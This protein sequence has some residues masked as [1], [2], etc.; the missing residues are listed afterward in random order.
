MK[1]TTYLLF[2]FLFLASITYAQEA[3]N[4]TQTV[5]GTVVDK[6]LET[7]LPGAT[8]ILLNTN[9]PVGAVTDAD[10]KFEMKV[11]FGRQSF[12]ASFIG[13]EAQTIPEVLV[14]AGKQVSLDIKL[15]ESVNKIK[16][17]T[18]SANSEKDRASNEYSTVSARTFSM[19]EVTRY[20]GGRND[21]ARLV[22][23]FA[24]VNTSNDARNDIV[25][26]GN[27]PAGILWRLEGIPIPNPNHF[28]TLGT[29][30]GPVSALN[31]NLL[32][33][34]DFLT[35]AF[36]AEYGNA[37]GGVFDVGF[38]SGNS[39]KHEF[40]FQLNMFSG[41]EAMAEGPMKKNKDASYLISYR[42]SFAGIGAAM[43][44]P[45]GTAAAPQYQDLS[46]KFD[47]ANSKKFGKL[48]VFGIGAYS[49]INF[50]G[51]KLTTED[52]F[53]DPYSDRYV[54][55]GFGVL[56]IK[57]T[58][59]AGK[60]AYVKTVLSGSF[61]ASLF[62][63][64][65]FPDS[66]A[67]Q[68]VVS[69]KDYTGAIRLASYY[70]KKFSPKLSLRAGITEEVYII[71]SKLD[72][73]DG[74]PDW[75]SV[76]NTNGVLTTTQPFAQIQY[77]PIA[78]ITWNVGV[79]GQ[80]LSY[81]NTWSIEP[82]T[83]FSYQPHP[84]HTISV[85][86]GW[87]SQLQ[88][89]PVYFYKARNADG[90]YD[91]SNKNLDFTRAHHIVLSYDVKI[92]NDWRI[93][94]EPYVQFI[95]GAPV[96]NSS[97]SFSMLNAGASFV[98]PDKGFLSNKGVGRNMGVEFTLEKFFSHGFYGLLTASLFDS[99][100]KGSDQVWRNTT[101]NSHY[102]V[103]FLAG[104]EFKVG[105]SKRNAITTDLKFTTSGGK[106]YT[107]I[108]TLAS[109]AAKS[110]VLQNDKAFSKQYPFY[111][112]LDVKF[113][114][115]LNGKKGKVSH[116]FYLDLQNVTFHK[117]L[118]ERRYNVQTGKVNDVYQIGFFPDVMYRIQF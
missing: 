5:R 85:A 68:Q 70:N 32:K 96:E 47:L 111:L 44:L 66:V 104:K 22:A 90:S 60:N 81:N 61:Q 30:G 114:F 12:K 43:G 91:L 71:K 72:S 36:A 78:K 34:S 9:P 108:D 39:N 21:V 118:F 37:N 63:Q 20:S 7:P 17:V 48:S 112:R 73:R 25:V 93:K 116:S 99:K 97:S 75:I 67:R 74:Y 55:S 38:R 86:Y 106:W 3:S 69:G 64:Y 105:K 2:F 42:Y 15:E 28:S 115:R 117:N 98:F 29:T 76:R 6:V 65:N 31:T 79:H 8:V 84:R 24:G 107:P 13:Y 35:G 14:S 92:A 62:D 110:E 49:Y 52:L 89:F 103:N 23:N 18:V 40:L 26:R 56:G 101:F 10:G 50:I 41:I 102:V 54:K 16:E 53:A 88:P 46:F 109:A 51:K 100:Y 58:I 77:K 95:T 59:N 19:D 45:I 87:H 4:G 80:Y 82:R 94:L 1:A 57:H 11:P 113:G 27:S 83:S 33:N